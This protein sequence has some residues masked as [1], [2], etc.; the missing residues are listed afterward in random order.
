MNKRDLT[1]KD[2]LT[3]LECIDKAMQNIIHDGLNF[4]DFSR[5]EFAGEV[6]SVI[7][8]GRSS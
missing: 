1:K 8:R 5:E 6:Y 7:K 3:V 4:N 2:V